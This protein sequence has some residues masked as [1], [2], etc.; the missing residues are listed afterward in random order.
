MKQFTRLT[1]ILKLCY[2]KVSNGAP[3][4][5]GAVAFFYVL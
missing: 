5:R 3:I 2:Y 1:N 4:Q